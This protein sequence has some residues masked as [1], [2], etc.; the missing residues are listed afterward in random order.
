MASFFLMKPVK[1]M[2]LR[3]RAHI[4]N[5]IHIRVYTPT[6]KIDTKERKKRERERE[7][8]V[9]IIDKKNYICSYETY[10]ADVPL[11]RN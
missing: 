10:L 2:I 7:L 11:R 1:S 6:I 4:K 8:H 5:L 3:S 9:Q